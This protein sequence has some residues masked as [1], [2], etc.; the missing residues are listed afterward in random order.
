[1]KTEEIKHLKKKDTG[2]V[3]IAT[4]QLINRMEV[5][6]DMEPFTGT[7]PWES[8][9][10]RSTISFNE[11]ATPT[12]NQPVGTFTEEGPVNEGDLHEIT[13]VEATESHEERLRRLQKLDMVNPSPEDTGDSGDNTPALDSVNEK[14]SEDEKIKALR[15][16]GKSLSAIGKIIGKSKVAVFKRLRK[17]AKTGGNEQ[18]NGCGKRLGPDIPQKTV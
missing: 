10:I 9:Q 16:E 2:E 1:M 15:D 8:K 13:P 12:V 7:P 11:E 17:L 3:F 4:P 5:K 14:V 18:V 6:G